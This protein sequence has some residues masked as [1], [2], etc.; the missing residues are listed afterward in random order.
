MV[1]KFRALPSVND[2][3]SDPRIAELVEKYSH[4]AIVDI[5]REELDGARSSISSGGE[6]PDADALTKSVAAEAESRWRPWPQGVINATGVVLHTNLGRAPLSSSSFEAMRVAAA[7]YS[8]L[9]FDLAA[10]RRGSRQQHV[11]NLICQTTGAEAALAVNNNA[12]AVMLGLAAI[13]TGKEVIVSRGEAVEI[14]GGFRIPDVLSQSGATLV[15]VGTTNRTYASDFASAI[16]ERT[17]AILSVHASNFRV[18][19]FTHAPTTAELVNVGESSGV[20]VLHDLGSGCLL[21]SSKYG[22]AHEPMPQE[23]ISAG[24]ALSFFSGDK[25]LGGPQAG[26][27]AGQSEYVATVSRHPLARA[28]RIDKLSMAALSA[29]LLHYINGDPESEVPVW[30]MISATIAELTARA[31]SWKSAAGPGAS[32][33]SARSAIGGGSL[34]G[35]TLESVALRIDCNELGTTPDVALSELRKGTPPVIGRIEDDSVM[36]DPRTVLP[37][38]DEAVAGTIQRLMSV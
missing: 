37:E 24:V 32:V 21:D 13:A 35:E 8:D 1:S 19:G 17:G 10:G 31:D 11:S 22:L 23:S 16:N 28:V 27:I 26:I 25:L 14:G 30:R 9:E 15:E 12:S 34:P 33:V 2:V 36:L 29:T 6:P 20:P 7:G 3:L 5:V 4:E 18:M 38:Q